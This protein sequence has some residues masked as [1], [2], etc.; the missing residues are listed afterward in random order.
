MIIGVPKETKREEYRTGMTPSGVKEMK[1]D[2]HRYH[3]RS[4][5]SPWREDPCSDH[6]RDASYNEERRRDR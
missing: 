1:R 4:F 6:E 5:V 2:G 3:H